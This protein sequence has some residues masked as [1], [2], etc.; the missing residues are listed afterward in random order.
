MQPY[1]IGVV[2]AVG[3][4]IL[5]VEQG[6]GVGI[7][8][9][10]F[11]QCFQRHPG[12]GIAEMGAQQVLRSIHGAHAAHAQQP[13]DTITFAQ[14]LRQYLG[15]A[16]CWFVRCGR[17]VVRAGEAGEFGRLWLF[18]CGRHLGIHVSAADY[19]G[20]DIVPRRAGQTLIE[21]SLE[22]QGGRG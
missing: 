6:V 9:K 5:A 7:F 16:G 10:A 2:Q 14:Y 22:C 15:A 12:F 13:F 18:L 3:Q 4:G 21:Q 20:T 1:D 11:I 19:H 8:Q 17:S